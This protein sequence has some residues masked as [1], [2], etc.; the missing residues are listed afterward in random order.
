MTVQAALAKKRPEG[1]CASAWSLFADAELDDSVLAVLGLDNLERVGAV[2]DERIELPAGQQLT[3]GVECADAPDVERVGASAIADTSVITLAPAFA[4]HRTRA[5][6]ERLVDEL[7]DPQTVRQRGRQHDPRVCHRPLVVEA[8]RHSI[9]RDER[10][11]V[12][13]R[14]GD[15]LT[16]RRGCPNQ[17]LQ[18]PAQEVISPVRA[19]ASVDRGLAGVHI[20]EEGGAAEGGERSRILQVIRRMCDNQAGRRSGRSGR[21][22]ARARARLHHRR[23]PLAPLG[24]ERRT[25]GRLEAPTAASRR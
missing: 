15:L 2:G 8:H 16:E 6:I 14:V 22:A 10:R 5:Q 17:P 7:L 13:H 4:R 11:P 23:S 18:S 3:L 12:V 1:R 20:Q 21:R 9:R 25:A 19:D 24:R